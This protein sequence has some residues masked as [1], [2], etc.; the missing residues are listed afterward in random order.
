MPGEDSSLHPDILNDESSRCWL[1]HVGTNLRTPQEGAK[2][3][4]RRPA[5]AQQAFFLGGFTARLVM[6][7]IKGGESRYILARRQSCRRT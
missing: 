6:R 1:L 5:V 7:F 3:M 2:H 4:R